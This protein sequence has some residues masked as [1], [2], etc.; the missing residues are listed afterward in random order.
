MKTTAVTA[1]A[2]V[3]A[4]AVYLLSDYQDPAQERP[5]T[6]S[7]APRPASQ[8][9]PPPGFPSAT[10]RGWSDTDPAVN[11][12]HIFEG[13]TNRRGKPVGFHFRPEG[14]DPSRARMTQ[15]RDGPNYIG[16]YT[17]DVEILSRTGRWLKKQSTFY[18]DRMDREEVLAAILYA[19]KEREEVEGN[20]FRGPSGEGFTIEGYT[21]DG[22]SINTAYPIYKA[23]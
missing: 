13:G 23:D 14:K 17:A 2:L 22:G 3:L 7:E 20:R 4:V 21:T 11:L 16:V 9:A 10:E 1:L 19:W 6:A 5:A 15:L 8:G 12:E 18:P